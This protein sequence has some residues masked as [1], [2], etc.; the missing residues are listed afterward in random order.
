MKRHV[1]IS[2][3][4]GSLILAA[5]AML[6][7]TAAFAN[8][9]DDWWYF[10][11]DIE[12]GGRF[13]A[14][15]PQKD[16]LAS[17]GQKALG[18]YYEYSTIKPGAFV[19]GWLEAGTKN[20]LYKFDLLGDNVG[21]SDQRIELNGSKAGEFYFSGSWDQTPHV[22]STNAQ[23]LYSGLG[24]NSLTLPAGLANT[25]YGNCG[26]PT[27]CANPAAAQQNIANNLYT[28]ELGIR[29]DTAAV[30]LRWTPDSTWDVQVAYSNMHRTGSQV[31]GIAFGPG[32]SN[33]GVAQVPKPV[34]D[35]T[36]NFALSGEYSGVSP[37]GQSLSVKLGYGGSIYTDKWNS[38]TVDDPFCSNANTGLGGSQPG[39]C[40][41]TSANGG[42]MYAPSALVS[43]WPSNQSNGF[44][45]TFGADLPAKSRYMGTVTYTMM[46]QNDAFTAFTNNP[47]P[48]LNGNPNPTLPASSLNGAINTILSNN[49]LTTD[50]TSTLKSKL[51]YRYYDMQ[52]NTPELLFNDFILTDT[53][54]AN[55]RST[56][57]APVQSLSIAY[58]KQNAGADLNWR[59]DNHWNLGG[60]YGWEGY[61]WTRADVN[62][63]NEHQGKAFIDY[64]PWVWL[65][66]RATW[67]TSD[68]HYDT[69]DY[70]G[71]VGN[72]Q[73]ADASCQ[74]A[75]G[76]GSQYSTAMRQF[77]LD[78]R[79]RNAGKLA[80]AV[81]LEPG[82]TITPTF[83]YQEDS[84]SIS[85]T[86]AGLT[87]TQSIKSGVELAYAINA[88]SNILLSYMNEQNRQNLKYT[89]A[90]SSSPMT[91]ATTW[92]SDIRDRVNTFTATVNWGAIPEKLD[93]RFSYALS[94]S[95]DG[96]QMNADNGATPSTATGGQFPDAKTQWS[97]FE[98][99]AKYTFDKGT[100]RAAGFDGDMYVKLRYVWERNSVNNLDQD[101]MVP[102]ILSLNG[103]AS[104]ERM[105]WMAYNNPNYNVHL[106]GAALGV[107][108]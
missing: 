5:A 103:S 95:S 94:L 22:Y 82:F 42:N 48:Y 46:R 73:W 53:T 36:Q 86:E 15:N 45:A 50:I 69:Y 52:N 14:N 38:Y 26:Q 67:M 89:T 84:Y 88:Y 57:Y 81:D 72:F 39:L 23:T 31:D 65:A 61:N 37:W 11:G 35:T 16:G 32:T 43:L 7:S 85:A 41:P 108:W 3:V 27:G 6:P 63:T 98:A 56:A 18:K 24:T 70:R 49:V 40:G 12:F 9:A 62:A 47:T 54:S 33:I 100:I 93:L 83:G 66:A 102:Y 34:N 59:P 17:S 64:K 80:I 13:F 55:N 58:T 91:A 76:C 99:L 78:N 20:G 8:A 29:R 79:L 105:T 71:Y 60:S 68:R 21:Y 44:N 28:T 74:S 30:D 25:L 2:G 107:K 87:R 104:L 97:R 51:S 75:A 77:Y 106:V 4:T 19:G 96:Q 10:H 92:H 101:L 90:S 1:L